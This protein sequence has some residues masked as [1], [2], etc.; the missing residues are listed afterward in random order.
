MRITFALLLFPLLQ[1]PTGCSTHGGNAVTPFYAEIV[2]L[3]S[4]EGKPQ[5]LNSPF[6]TT[7]NRVY[8]VGFQDGTFPDLGW[9]IQGEM[10]GLWD[11]PIKRM[12]L[13][14]PIHSK[15]TRNHFASIRPINLSITRWRTATT[16]TGQRNH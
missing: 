13:S 7:G 1:L 16:L 14:P 5:Y 4:L 8:L 9:H 12:A 3:P 10:G 6:A 11:H 2:K 15:K